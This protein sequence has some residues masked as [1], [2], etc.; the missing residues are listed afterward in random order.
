[1]RSPTTT[2]RTIHRRSRLRCWMHPY[3]RRC[4]RPARTN[5]T[6]LRRRDC[7]HPRCRRRLRSTS[8]CSA[9]H[10]MRH[11]SSPTSPRPACPKSW[12][13]YCPR[14]ARRGEWIQRHKQGE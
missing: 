7:R 11:W 13:S 3:P 12:S 10:S 14:S 4:C 1:L 2:R 8:R 5:L 6:S 9:H